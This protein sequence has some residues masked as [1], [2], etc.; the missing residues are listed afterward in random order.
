[1]KN[2]LKH[3]F[4]LLLSGTLLGPALADGPKVLILMSDQN[5]IYRLI[6]QGIREKVSAEIVACKLQDGEKEALAA[7]R[8]LKPDLVIAVGNAAALW[9][10][11]E[12]TGVPL[13]ASGV[14]HQSNPA[15]F[16]KMPGVSLDCSLQSYFNLIRELAPAK[17]KV[18]LVIGANHPPE[19]K[20]RLAEL[21][22]KASLK[23]RIVEVKKVNEVSEAVERVFRD[24]SEVF[25][26]TYDPLIMNPESFKYLVDFSI[27]NNLYLVA[28]SR[29]LLKGGALA[30]LE[31]DYLDI[32]RRTA[33]IANSILK[34][35][36][37]SSR[38][39]LEFPSKEEVS[40]N[41][42]IANSL[43]VNIPPSVIKKAVYVQE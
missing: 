8:S 36:G 42:K 4:S 24:G 18:G 26:M 2:I 23:I 37:L 9:A 10:H 19:F 39:E 34:D 15:V 31:A 38:L 7:V 16:S 28:P 27:S 20:R 35:S 41:R 11:A 21:A 29:A 12:I 13:L 5:S 1:M 30:S 22:E 25:L 6:D 33:E 32:G 14:I 3:F 43:R 40:V 17:G